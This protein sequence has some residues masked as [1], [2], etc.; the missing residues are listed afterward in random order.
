MSGVHRVFAKVF[1]KSQTLV[2]SERLFRVP[3]VGPYV[4]HAVQWP[5]AAAWQWVVACRGGGLEHLL[6]QAETCKRQ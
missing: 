3:H 5:T 2:G 4:P 6:N 1:F